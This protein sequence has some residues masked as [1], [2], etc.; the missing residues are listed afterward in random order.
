MQKQIVALWR[1]SPIILAATKQLYERFCPP[2][3]LSVY[4][5]I[6]TVLRSSYH[7]EICM[8]Y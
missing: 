2:V 7:H 4:H 6:F 1:A 5:T 8:S 3:C